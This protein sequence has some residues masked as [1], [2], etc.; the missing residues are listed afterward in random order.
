MPNTKNTGRL[1][2]VSETGGIK[3]F[4][5]RPSPSYF[6]AI[7]G[8]VVFAIA[9][10]LLHN[11]LLPRDCPRVTYYAGEQTTDA[12][13]DKFMGGAKAS[14]IVIVEDGWEQRIRESVL[15]CYE[16]PPE[17]FT[18]LDECAG[19]HISYQQV[20]PIAEYCIDN[21]LSAL[22]SR[23]VELRFMPSL[24]GIAEEVKN[25]SL[26]FSLIRMRNAIL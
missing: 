20:T 11:Y 10:K 22:Q 9:D 12:D 7:T 17:D 19:Y 26:N 13:K 25:S 23:D 1:F 18:L 14:H 16:F 24:V 21:V 4:Q 6:A 8:D 5:P 15:Y 2:H 3:L